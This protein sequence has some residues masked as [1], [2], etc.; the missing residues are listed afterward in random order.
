MAQ[1]HQGKEMSGN[2]MVK[3]IMG[4][5]V[6]ASILIVIVIQSFYVLWEPKERKQIEQ[7]ETEQPSY[8]K[9]AFYQADELLRLS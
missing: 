3:I 7:D 4:T 8:S 5:I 9:S 6:V 2:K 1:E